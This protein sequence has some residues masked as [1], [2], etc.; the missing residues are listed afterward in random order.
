MMNAPPRRE[1]H[2][3]EDWLVGWLVGWLVR[4]SFKLRGWKHPARLIERGSRAIAREREQ[5]QIAL[6][7]TCM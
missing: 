5:D 3:P 2:A 4:Y 7:T 1:N 6:P